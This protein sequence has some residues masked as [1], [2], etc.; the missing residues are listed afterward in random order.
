MEGPRERP[1][2]S[3][4][5][6]PI[7]LPLVAASLS[8]FFPRESILLGL[9]VKMLLLPGRDEHMVQARLTTFSSPEPEAGVDRSKGW[10]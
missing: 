4:R 7:F 3:I 2:V 10:W 1:A 8:C 5:S 9:L 6:A